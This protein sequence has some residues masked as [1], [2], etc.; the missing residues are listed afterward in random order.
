MADVLST[1][2]DGT[3]YLIVGSDS[4]DVQDLI[5]AGLDPAG[6]AD[7]GGQRS[8]TMLLLRFEDGEAKMMSIPRDLYVPIAETDGSSKINAAYNGGPR[9]LVL[10]IEQALQHPDPPLHGGRLRQLRQAGRLAR[11]DHDRLPAPGLRPE[12]GPRHRRRPV[13]TTSTV[14][15][16][17]PSCALATSS[18]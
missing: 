6:F 15:R 1:G 14:R 16:R 13:P 2:G 17:W 7:G 10:T 5:D 18:R 3:N 4:R 12:L 8:D 9:R 11:R